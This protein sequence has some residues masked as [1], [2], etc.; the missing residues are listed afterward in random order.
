MDSFD[1]FVTKVE[2]VLICSAVLVMFVMG[3]MQIVSRFIIKAPI[4]WSEQLLTVLFIWTSYLGASVA[5]ARR[6]HFQVDVFVALLPPLARKI[7]DI[8]VDC[9]VVLFCVFLIQKGCFLF[10]RTAN[11]SMAM[12]PFSIR[13]AYLCIPVAALGM[14]IHSL[15]HI[16][17][18]LRAKP[19][20]TS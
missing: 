4:A 1:R 16:W 8:A 19:E 13:W 10:E 12:L 14:A 3:M 11:Q 15:T 6:G 2:Q 17:N 20:T 5:L 7:V 9:V 18:E